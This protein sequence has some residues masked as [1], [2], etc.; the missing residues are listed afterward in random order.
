MTVAV[1]RIPETPFRLEGRRVWVAGHR[2][3][4]GSALVRRLASEDV[5]ILTA[6]RTELDLTRQRDV[7]RWMDRRRPDVVVL[8]AAKVGGI[9]AN[10]ARPMEFLHD[11]LAIAL[12]VIAAAR[13]FGVAKLVFLGSSC[14]YPKHAPQ[15]IGEDALLTGPLEITNEAYAIAK[16]AGM[17]FA[18]YCNRAA[19]RAFISLMPT[20]LYGPNDDFDPFTSHAMPGIIRKMHEAKAAMRPSVTLLG[21]GAPRREF[22]HADDLADAIVF[23]IRHYAA[24]EPINVGW[25][26]DITI[27]ELAERVARIVGYEGEIAFD[28]TAPD[29][30]P[31][32]LLDV[33]RM[34]ALGWT[35]KIGLETGIASTYR[36]W[37]AGFDDLRVA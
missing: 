7:E 18:E 9:L 15:P 20:N 21:T 31:R 12:N 16:I 36:H 34:T 10:A 35:P 8:A 25:G 28:P 6:D 1:D 29:G 3:L 32:K 14:V 19:G 22:L 37:A 24:P 13:A 17:K 4:A 5:E 27:R 33:S 2:G 23:L 30:T 26:K 11:N